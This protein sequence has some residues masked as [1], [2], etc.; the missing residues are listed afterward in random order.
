MSR[1]HRHLLSN[2]LL[3]TVL[4]ALPSLG[5][6]GRRSALNLEFAFNQGTEGWSAGF[7]DLPEGY[8]QGAYQLESGCENLPD[9]QDTTG[10]AFKISGNNASDDLFMFLKRRLDRGSYISRHPF[11]LS[12]SCLSLDTAPTSPNNP[13]QSSFLSV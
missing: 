3:L 7:V 12:S 2:L 13:L 10:K 6:T 1:L 9:S 11:P 4:L 8:D 5:C